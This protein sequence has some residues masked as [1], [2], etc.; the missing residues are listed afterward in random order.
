M[1][2]TL[3]IPEDD[4]PSLNMSNRNFVAFMELLQVHLPDGCFGAIDKE[5]VTS[6]V[7]RICSL[8]HDELVSFITPTTQDGNIIDCGRD[9]E[10]ARSRLR[11]MLRLC[12]RA[13]ELN[14][15]ILFG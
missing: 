15:S 14:Q 7:E 5:Q 3:F 9:L 10:Y 2:V 1:S 11:H 6:V 4:V 13:I 8:E 12:N